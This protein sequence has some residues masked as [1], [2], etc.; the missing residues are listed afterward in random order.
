MALL[1]ITF[2]LDGTGIYY[3]PVN[4]I[5]LDA[6]IQWALVPMRVP[7]E[8]RNPARDEEPYYFGL[9]IKSEEINGERVY[10]ASSLIPEGSTN[11][12]MVHWR[13]KMRQS[14]LGMTKGSPNLKN[15][16]Y[17]EYNQPMPLLLTHK[18]VGWME[19]KPKDAKKLLSQVKYLGK[20]R[21]QGY[22]KIVNI[23]VEETEDDFCFYR[24]GITMRWLPNEGGSKMVRPQPPYWNCT[25]MV[26]CIDVFQPA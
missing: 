11:E 5:H 14:R 22:G 1:K 17:R 13:K 24:D 19:S 25:G 23:N 9:P 3:D 26:K 20:K 6:L 15:G 16:I 4:P 18:M 8:H 10:R 7:V 12:D 21:S 2:H